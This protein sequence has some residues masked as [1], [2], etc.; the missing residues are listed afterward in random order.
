M[1]DIKVTFRGRT[2]PS[3]KVTGIP[4]LVGIARLEQWEKSGKFD[5]EVEKPSAPKSKKK[6]KKEKA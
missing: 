2:A 6:Y 4:Y 3:G 5:I 1:K